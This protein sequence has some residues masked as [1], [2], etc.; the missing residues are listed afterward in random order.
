MRDGGWL[1]PWMIAAQRLHLPATVS[2]TD[3][4][5]IRHWLRV[6]ELPLSLG[7]LK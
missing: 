7:W 1:L 2:V 6:V 4:P 3:V 5:T